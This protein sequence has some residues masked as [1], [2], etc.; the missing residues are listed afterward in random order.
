MKKKLKNGQK[1]RFNQPVQAVLMTN[2]ITKE[3][4]W[5]VLTKQL[6][7]PRGKPL[8]ISPEDVFIVEQASGALSCPAL[9]VIAR[10]ETDGLVIKF[11]HHCR[12]GI[13]LSKSLKE[14]CPEIN[15]V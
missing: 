9:L 14:K 1:F 11:N 13:W 7:T 8:S 15:I 5:C 12:E 3:K 10:R 2:P 4:T 6:K